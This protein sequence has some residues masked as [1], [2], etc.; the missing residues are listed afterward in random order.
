MARSTKHDQITFFGNDGQGVDD[1]SLTGYVND[2]H[3]ESAEEHRT[4][5]DQANTAIPSAAIQ[6]N[7]DEEIITDAEVAPEHTVR[8]QKLTTSKAPTPDVVPKKKK[9]DFFELNY[10]KS[11]ILTFIIYISDYIGKAFRN[12]FIA[13]LFTSFSRTESL[14]SDSFISKTV[15]AP[16]AKKLSTDLKKKSRRHATNAVFPT[17]ITNFF[18]SLVRVKTRIYGFGALS[19]GITALLVHF[20]I[21]GY[22]NRFV[23]NIYTPIT[24]IIVIISSIFLIVYNKTVSDG[25][26]ESVILSTLFFSFLGI[27]RPSFNEGDEIEFSVSGSCII[28]VLLGALSLFFPAHAIIATVFTLIY[29]FLVIKF[30]ET[31]V[32]SFILIMPILNNTALVYISTVITCSYLFKMIIGKRTPSFEF[33]D[34]FV[35]FFLILSIISEFVTFGNISPQTMYTPAFI[36]IYFLCIFTLRDPAWFERAI[37]SL[38]LGACVYAGYSIFATFLGES[39]A[40]NIDYTVN[41]DYGSQTASVFGST[42]VLAMVLLT[43]IYFILATFFTSKSKSNRF[44]FILI[45]LISLVFMFRE[46]SVFML[47]AM[48]IGLIIFMVLKSSKTVIFVVAAAVILPLLPLFN[49]GIYSGVNSLLGDESYRLEIW[50]A[51]INMLNRYGFT[52]IGAAPD[53]FSKLYATYYVGNTANVPHAH[54]IIFQIAITLGI[55]GLIVFTMIIFFIMQGAFSYGRN[56]AN[57]SSKNRLYC[58]AGMCA[59][60]SMVIAGIAENIWYNPKIILLF[61]LMCGI[62]VCARRSANDI[63]DSDRLMLEINEHYNG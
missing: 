40:L 36:L 30:P 47:A 44:G 19:F 18:T 2:E 56:A 21:H 10:R 15:T 22:F 16:K 4:D 17:F 5:D 60:I 31:G 7:D 46:V 28:G 42:S 25:I 52:G 35:A 62:T 45:I 24:A 53:A 41:T 34:L 23:A 37:N 12:S 29:T 38:I 54:S 13:T 20:F 57:K 27:K 6:Q 8:P 58:Y 55:P 48:I 51:V 49:S 3:Y 33:P 9:S 43:G 26:K 14:F 59:V 11:I 39:L 63:S 32:I 61:W 1:Q 50:S